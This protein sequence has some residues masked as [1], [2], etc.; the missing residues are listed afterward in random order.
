[1]KGFSAYIAATVAI[2]L[3][4]CSTATLPAYTY[5]PTP[6]V[7]RAAPQRSARFVAKNESNGLT[8]LGYYIPGATTSISTEVACND[9]Q[10]ARITIYPASGSTGS[11][12]VLALADG[13]VVPASII[14][15]AVPAIT[16]IQP[17]IVP[18]TIAPSPGYYP[19]AE[20]GSCYGDIST[21]TGRPKTVSVRGY[22]R[23]DGTY[24]R[25]HYRSSPRR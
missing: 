24:V 13:T 21:L 6:V 25:G 2:V 16:S 18:P 11:W 12:G 22:Y 20:N 8:C 19:C 17:S 1:M 14:Y 9:G 10:Q 3:A 23:S 7:Q 15:P 4:G 5:T